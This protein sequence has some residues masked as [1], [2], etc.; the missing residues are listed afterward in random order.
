MMM[1][2]ITTSFIK[3]DADEVI[4]D[5]PTSCVVHSGMFMRACVQKIPES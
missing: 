2:M 3:D 5:L 4:S 1:I